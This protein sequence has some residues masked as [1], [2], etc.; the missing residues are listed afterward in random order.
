MKP[1][2]RYCI[3][4]G[5]R[6]IERCRECQREEAARAEVKE[7]RETEAREEAREMEPGQFLHQSYV[8]NSTRIENRPINS[9]LPWVELT[10]DSKGIFAAMEE[11]VTRRALEA[12]RKATEERAILF[13]QMDKENARLREALAHYSD[14]GNWGYCDRSKDFQ[15]RLTRDYL[16]KMS[17]WD[18]ARAALDPEGFWG[19]EGPP[20]PE[21]ETEEP[22]G[23]T[24][25]CG[26][27]TQMLPLPQGWR[28]VNCR[29]HRQRFSSDRKDAPPGP[30][31]ETA[32]GI[33]IP[34]LFDKVRFKGN[35][36]VGEVIESH[37]WCE[38]GEPIK[39][40]CK[41]DFDPVICSD[42][43]TSELVLVEREGE[44]EPAPAEATAAPPALVSP[45]AI[46]AELKGQVE[47]LEGQ[48]SEVLAWM[49]KV[50]G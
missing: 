6:L 14:E 19:P 30:A 2:C 26:Y 15:M 34:Q 16:P 10:S 1:K 41:V 11:A 49:G 4:N 50:R 31:E 23:V 17:G 35:H 18:V 29:K 28:S 3:Y 7:S 38:K 25:F 32:T 37:L 12:H 33:W 40:T 20:Q 13:V 43:P 39:A 24:T 5:D 45:L 44:E 36:Q 8:E 9:Y 27:C 22:D 47:R 48:M 46:L 21:E 42:I